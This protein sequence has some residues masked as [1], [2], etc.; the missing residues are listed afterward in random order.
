MKRIALNLY[1]NDPHGLSPNY[2][3]ITMMINYLL[4][5]TGR[6]R[7]HQDGLRKPLQ[8]LT[9]AQGMVIDCVTDPKPAVTCPFRI[10]HALRL[11][12]SSRCSHC[13]M[14]M[15]LTA[16]HPAASVQPIHRRLLIIGVPSAG[17]IA[18]MDKNMAAMMIKSAFFMIF[19]FI[20]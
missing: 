8:Y 13:T 19:E 10:C 7:R 2:K 18:T 17:I 5:V 3:P 12:S 15:S 4:Y 9:A 20:V 1:A 6:L 11:F 14:T 16:I